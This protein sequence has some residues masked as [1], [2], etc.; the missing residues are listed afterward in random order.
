MVL[1]D[2]VAGPALVTA[3]DSHHGVFRGIIRMR[4]AVSRGFRGLSV[5]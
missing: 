4:K 1:A 3:K 2:G 5:S